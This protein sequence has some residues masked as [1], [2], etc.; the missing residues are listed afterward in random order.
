MKS[1]G[2]GGQAVLEGIMMRYKNDVAVAVRKTN[3]EIVVEKHKMTS[4]KDKHKWMGWPLIRGVVSFVSSLVIGIKTLME[5][6]EY[7]EV[8]EEEEQEESQET[9]DK[10]SDKKKEE[11]SGKGEAAMMT[12]TLIVAVILAVAIFLLLPYYAAAG[13]MWLI[14]SDSTTLL[15]I[16]E[17]ILKL[18]IFIGYI[19]AISFMEDIKRTFMYHGSE[20][21]CINCIETGHELTVDNVM[22]A[23]REH[24]RCG[25]SFIFF[26]LIISIIFFIFL[27]FDNRLLRFVVRI[28]LIPV[29]AGVSYEFIQWAGNTNSKIA[30]VLSKPGLWVQ[31]LT[32]R[33]PTPD[34]V[35]VAICSVEAVFDWR[36]YLRENGYEVSDP[37]P[38]AV[39][40]GESEAG[41]AAADM[42]EDQDDAGG[43]SAPSDPLCGG[44]TL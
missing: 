23:S 36:G 25:T 19:A 44:C 41:E 11:K 12:G 38:E 4:P 37:E 14:G 31:K 42:T 29:I 3:G 26:V 16:I 5:S 39:P 1:S 34:M 35:E 20:H 15:A 17:G 8:D 18:A 30:A 6:A 43:A 7:F 28:L 27:R 33:E 24:R 40:E 9:A 21:K 22:A 10:G 32:T 13:I 2:I